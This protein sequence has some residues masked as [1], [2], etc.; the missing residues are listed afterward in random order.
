MTLLQ[1]LAYKFLNNFKLISNAKKKFPIDCIKPHKISF[2]F[3]K[4]EK[5]LLVIG[6]I[7]YINIL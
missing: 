1:K 5:I 3:S 6:I 4:N 2:I 7:K